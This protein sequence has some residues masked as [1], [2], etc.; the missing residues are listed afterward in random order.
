MNQDRQG[1]CSVDGCANHIYARRLCSKHYRKERAHGD[2]NHNSD[3]GTRKT[4]T[5]QGYV[6][7]QENGREVRE[8][9]RV[10]EEHL[11]R[12]LLTNES[13]HH[14]NGDRGD[15]RLE[16]L[17]LWSSSQPAGQRVADKVRWA[18]AILDLYSDLEGHGTA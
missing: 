16:N 5:K 7:W 4:I 10:M 3:W 13:V 15:N 14:I 6:V 1:L 17:E 12:P 18:Q 8:H 2:P 11:G 9:R